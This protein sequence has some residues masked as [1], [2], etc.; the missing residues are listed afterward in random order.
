M[1]S[2]KCLD[3]QRPMPVPCCKMSNE[4]W[5]RDHSLS[6]LCNGI[7]PPESS[8]CRKIFPSTTS[9]RRRIYP[10]STN[11]VEFDAKFRQI[12]F[13]RNRSVFTIKLSG[14]SVKMST[15]APRINRIEATG[16]KTSRLT[17]VGV[18]FNVSFFSLV[19][20]RSSIDLRSSLTNC[21]LESMTTIS[22]LISSRRCSFATIV[23]SLTFDDT[24]LKA[25]IAEASGLRTS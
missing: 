1:S 20:L 13:S 19:L 21:K 5:N 4:S 9:A 22:A 16:S 6:R 12:C 24:K 11:L 15:L 17:S 8:T 18:M 14:H 10:F 25:A 2:L 23:G 3:R 7:P